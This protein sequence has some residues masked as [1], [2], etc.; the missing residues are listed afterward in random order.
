MCLD[1][2]V[3]CG[4][5]QKNNVIP[6]HKLYATFDRNFIDEYTLGITGDKIRGGR[7]KASMF[8]NIFNAI[9][10]YISVYFF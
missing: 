6:N 10:T 9:A 5:K 8:M 4:I 7:D 3:T 1:L 2:C